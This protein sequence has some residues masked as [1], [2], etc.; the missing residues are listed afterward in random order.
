M[1]PVYNELRG[2]C[3]ALEELIEAGDFTE[4]ELKRL[5][6]AVTVMKVGFKILKKVLKARLRQEAPGDVLSFTPG[7]K[8]R[9]DRLGQ[10]GG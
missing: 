9:W 5:D 7:Q 4:K 1:L 6:K 3:A 2:H 10:T 8:E